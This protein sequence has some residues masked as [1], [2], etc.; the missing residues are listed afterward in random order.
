MAKSF[1]KLTGV[2]DMI[3]R[4]DALPERVDKGLRVAGRRA[5]A[6][7]YKKGIRVLAGHGLNQG[8]VV[9]YR[10]W[11]TGVE[12]D[13]TV[14]LWLGENPLRRTGDFEA[15]PSGRRQRADVAF[16]PGVANEI[17]AEVLPVVHQVYEAEAESAIKKAIGR[18]R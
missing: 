15:S 9:G 7:G 2:E 8:T 18:G 1:E 11:F 12:P 10:R 4:L 6:A 16:P 17:T 5:S 3:A 14:N 13:G